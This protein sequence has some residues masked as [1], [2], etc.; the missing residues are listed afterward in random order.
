MIGGQARRVDETLGGLLDQAI[1]ERYCDRRGLPGDATRCGRTR[2]P[3][4]SRVARGNPGF[5]LLAIATLAL[6]I[7][8]T[9]I[10][11][12]VVRD[13]LLAPFPYVHQG[14]DGGRRPARRGDDARA[15]RSLSGPEFLDY[16]EQARSFVEAVLELTPEGAL[17]V[18]R[19]LSACSAVWVTPNM[20]SFLGVAPLY[21]RVV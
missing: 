2:H 3:G 12:S 20:F 16:Q 9:A 7:G 4:V 10:I 1:R 21:G 17:R 19:R 8:S 5:T 14:S 13:I 18:R 15:P 6:G 11:Y